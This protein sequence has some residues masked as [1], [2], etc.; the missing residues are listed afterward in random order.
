[1][2]PSPTFFFFFFLEQDKLPSRFSLMPH[3]PDY[4]ID[5]FLTQALAWRMA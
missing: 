2:A 3:S 1:M 5:L 4:V